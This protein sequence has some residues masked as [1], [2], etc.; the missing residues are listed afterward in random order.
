[1]SEI[2]FMGLPYVDLIRDDY[3]F[4]RT[5]I[6]PEGELSSP[7]KYRL[8]AGGSAL[9]TIRTIG[10]LGV[11]QEDIAYVGVLGEE[12]ADPMGDMFMQLLKD[13][14]PNIQSTLVRA[15]GVQ[16][17]FSD[18]M[19]N[20]S[21]DHIMLASVPA[22]LAFTTETMLEAVVRIARNARI[23]YAGSCLKMEAFADGFEQLP[24]L[25]G[26]SAHIMVDHGQM[27]G[28]LSPRLTQAVKQF[29]P[30]VHTYLPSNKKGEFCDFWRVKTVRDGLHKLYDL[31]PGLTVIVKDGPNGAHYM[32]DGEVYTEP[33]IPVKQGGGATGLG[34]AF[35]GGYMTGIMSGMTIPEAVG[36]ANRAGAARYSGRPLSA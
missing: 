20:T 6:P 32:R 22:S 27:P 13:E 34:D 1:M 10:E 12:R 14:M 4:A 25:I 19:T 24:E 15:P 35:N 29:I 36:R 2:A 21:G 7:Q 9:N 16:T 28:G 33:A 18:N 3:P 26:D 23:F 11:A 8:A 31:A 30:Q 17:N 5:G